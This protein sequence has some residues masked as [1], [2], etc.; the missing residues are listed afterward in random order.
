MAEAF[1][2]TFR[3]DYVRVGDCPDA[4]TVPRS[5]PAWFTHDNE[6]HPPRALGHRSPRQ[7]IRAI[8]TTRLARSFGGTNTLARMP[9]GPHRVKNHRARPEAQ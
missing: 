3:R 5:L 4:R 1:V 8:L 6:V 2:R 9:V 7:F